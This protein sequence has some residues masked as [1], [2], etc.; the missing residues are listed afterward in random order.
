MIA[1]F[2]LF[3]FVLLSVIAEIQYG[4]CWLKKYIKVLYLKIISKAKRNRI[5][6]CNYENSI[7]KLV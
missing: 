4:V 7:K 6:Y 3:M 2:T 1:I 5:T